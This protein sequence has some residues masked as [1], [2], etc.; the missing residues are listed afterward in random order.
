MC[1]LVQFNVGCGF[2]EI[3]TKAVILATLQV[4]SLTYLQLLRL[5][6]RGLQTLIAILLSLR[7]SY[8]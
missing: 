2:S 7:G 8:P 1:L 4:I 3:W 6:I 5:A